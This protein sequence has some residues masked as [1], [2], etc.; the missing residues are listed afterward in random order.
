M[1]QRDSLFY[2]I[3]RIFSILAYS[4]ALLIS[5]RLLY[6]S[7]TLLIAG[8]DNWTFRHRRSSRSKRFVEP[9]PGL[10]HLFTGYGKHCCHLC[11]GWSDGV[12]FAPGMK[13]LMENF[14]VAINHRRFIFQ[15]K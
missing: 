12:P 9:N 4:P 8:G 14:W 11:V 1:K 15:A 7:Q 3:L 5:L 13:D 6:Y 10:H 2:K